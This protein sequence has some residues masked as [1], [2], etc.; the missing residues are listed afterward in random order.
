M[1]ITR[2]LILISLLFVFVMTD[3]THDKTV[4]KLKND[5]DKNT[6]DSI[7]NFNDEA[8]KNKKE[9]EKIAAENHKEHEEIKKSM[10]EKFLAFGTVVVVV[11]FVVPILL[12]IGASVITCILVRRCN[13]NSYGGSDGGY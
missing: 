3:D 9:H 4:S 13:R 10:W 5:F 1:F 7:K 6:A 12:S 8:A 11:V 2:G